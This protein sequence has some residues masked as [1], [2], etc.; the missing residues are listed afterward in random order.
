MSSNPLLDAPTWSALEP[1]SPEEYYEHV[2]SAPTGPARE[3]FDAQLSKLIEER[4]RKAALS[5]LEI[6]D[7]DE[8]ERLAKEAGAKG[9]MARAR[10]A[11][12]GRDCVRTLRSGKRGRPKAWHRSLEALYGRSR[13]S[14]R[15]RQNSTLASFAL[16]ILHRNWEPAFA[17]FWMAA[18]CDKEALAQQLIRCPEVRGRHIGWLESGRFTLLVELGRLGDEEEILAWARA[19]SLHTT[20]R[21]STKRCVEAVRRERL[22]EKRKNSS[23]LDRFARLADRR[24]AEGLAWSEIRGGAAD[25]FDA[26]SDVMEAVPENEPTESATPGGIP[27]TVSEN[28]RVAVEPPRVRVAGD[29]VEGVRIHAGDDAEAEWAQPRRMRA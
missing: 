2:G 19:F 18:P 25:L 5:V 13:G 7:W 16:F 9:D 12:P 1:S 26:L 24:K 15:T 23:T 20:V 28:V 21:A 17:W 3:Y 11:S 4:E 27:E 10:F 22:G 8:L 29:P 6:D 14:D